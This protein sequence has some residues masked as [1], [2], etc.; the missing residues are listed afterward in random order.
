MSDPLD[1]CAGALFTA[2]QDRVPLA[3]LDEWLTPGDLAAAY[4]V[5]DRLDARMREAGRVQVGWK[6]GVTSPVSL[7]AMGATEPMTGR[8]YADSVLA[9][10]ARFAPEQGCEP[11]LEG[12]VLF[13]LGHDALAAASDDAALAA[14]VVSVRPAFEIAD[15]R[16]AGWPRDV[17]HAI[18]DNALC[19]WLCPAAEGRAAE[20]I[21]FAAVAMTM[22]DGADT[23]SAGTGKDCLG[24]VRNS[25]RWFLDHARTRGLKVERGQWLLTGALGPAV[26][27]RAGARYRVALSGLGEVTLETTAVERA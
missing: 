15:A 21:D 24:D 1:L 10:P 16:V 4:A 26:P 3:S 25:L 17:A 9:A 13:E 23:V 18:A 20:R 12:E 8:I 11:R 14:M 2:W 19:G 27:P 22:D 7:A 5:Q 6:V